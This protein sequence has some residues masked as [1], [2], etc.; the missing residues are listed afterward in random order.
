MTPNFPRN[1]PRP[2]STGFSL[3]ELT[4]AL[5]IVVLLAGIAL[6]STN[7]LSFQVRYEQTQERLNRIKEA[8][9]GNP[10]RTVNG[11][12]DISGFVADMGRLPGSIRELLQPGAC[13]TA[14]NVLSDPPLACVDPG[15]SWRWFNGPCSDE[16]SQPQAACLTAGK[17]WLGWQIDSA[18]GSSLGYG[19]RGPY[20]TV[21]HNPASTDAITDGWGR[22]VEDNPSTAGINEADNLNYG[23]GFFDLSSLTGNSSDRHNL[24]IQSFGKNH[25]RDNV[26][27]ISANYD[28]DYPS[29]SNLFGTE[30]YPNPIVR[31]QD[32]LLD[33]SGGIS[34]NIAKQFGANKFCAFTG[35]ATKYATQAKCENAGG[36][37]GGASCSFDQ[38][39]CK[40]VGG[41]WNQCY[42][43]LSAC[44]STGGTQQVGCRFTE[45]SCNTAGGSGSWD[46]TARSCN[47]FSEQARCANAGG[48]WNS[49]ASRCDFT[50][51]S[52]SL[53][54]GAWTA[55]CEFTSATCPTATAGVTWENTIKPASCNFNYSACNALSGHSSGDNYC[56]LTHGENTGSKYDVASCDA[57]SGSW[58]KKICLTVFYR[59]NGHINSVSSQSVG[60]EENGG[61]QTINFTFN[62]GTN[63]PIGLNAIGIYEHDGTN[64]TSTPYPP[65][66]Q[67]IQTLFNARSGLPV[68]NW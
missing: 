58:A 52:C 37:W 32:W 66:R 55:E 23:W 64:C 49:G 59:E 13:V 8:I 63:V 9:I 36:S 21:T 39:S 42:L 25:Q 53:A 20:L 50:E 26:I 14:T 68:I 62:P 44:S 15:E 16:T 6:R 48:S 31:R 47:I 27:P 1:A 19:W 5:L 60:I 41:R 38:D 67:P 40:A 11:Q 54:G 12:P 43:V 29:N 4:V 34:V 35:P 7:E 56:Y 17:V 10:S 33:I 45:K 51:T 61:Y 24:I 2:P 65:S 18:L 46:T 30:Y 57:A 28:N 22:T 3:I